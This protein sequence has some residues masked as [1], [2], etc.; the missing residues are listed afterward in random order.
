MST[1]STSYLEHLCQM[2]YASL[3]AALSDMSASKYG[4][5]FILE[6]PRA[7]LSLK[8][9]DIHVL[10][11]ASLRTPTQISKNICQNMTLQMFSV[12]LPKHC[13]ISTLHISCCFCSFSIQW[14]IFHSFPLE[15][16]LGISDAAFIPKTK[17]TSLL[18]KAEFKAPKQPT[19]RPP[20][21]PV[22]LFNHLNKVAATAVDMACFFGQCLSE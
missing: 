7:V 19:S 4:L 21:L 1:L 16:L 6:N 10:L 9:Q 2:P 5:F 11:R 14:P 17:H 18:A 15:W 3:I 8:K 12:F 22:F 20:P 13:F